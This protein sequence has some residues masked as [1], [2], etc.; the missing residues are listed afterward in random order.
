MLGRFLF[1]KANV[2]LLDAAVSDATSKLEDIRSGSKKDPSLAALRKVYNNWKRILK[3]LKRHS[4]SKIPFANIYD[5]GTS[6]NIERFSLIRENEMVSAVFGC[7]VRDKDILD[8]KIP[9]R[10]R[11]V[12]AERK[13]YLAREKALHDPKTFLLRKAEITYGFDLEKLRAAL[14]P[15]TSVDEAVEEDVSPPGSPRAD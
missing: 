1:T 14:P 13:Q 11:D 10:V 15:V 9:P 12:E 3:T 4:N 5:L 7:F 6:Y 2:E 8:R